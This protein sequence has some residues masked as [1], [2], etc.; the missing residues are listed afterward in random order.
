MEYEGLSLDDLDNVRALNRVWLELHRSTEP[1]LSAKRL[2]RLANTPFLLFSFCE[3]DDV[4]WSELLG[5]RRQLDMLE[6]E[7]VDSAGLRELQAAGLGFLWEL[8]RRNPYVARIVSNASS[9]W[10][11]R[12][13][14]STLVKVLECA[15]YRM[16]EPRFED[17][18]SLKRRFLARGSALEREMRV[19]TQIGALQAMLTN[20]QAAQYGRLSAAACRMPQ[21]GRQ[22]ADEV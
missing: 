12:V 3:H 14:A 9:H 4:R 22:V 8:V 21:S 1:G 7:T 17:N 18:T 10:C 11:E 15:K 20:G 5:E 6:R 19:F 2:E 16:I 13:A